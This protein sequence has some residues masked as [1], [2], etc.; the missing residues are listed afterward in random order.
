MSE[1]TTEAGEFDALPAGVP[2]G[3]QP[4]LAYRFW[5]VDLGGTVYSFTGPTR[6]VGHEWVT[7]TC[8]WPKVPWEHAAPLEGCS[9]G[10]YALKSRELAQMFFGYLLRPQTPGPQ[11]ATRHGAFVGGVLELA[12][13]I[14][15]HDRGYRA[16]RV[17]IVEILP[18]A[19]DEGR[20]ARAAPHI[21]A[22]VAKQIG[23]RLGDPIEPIMD[24]Y[25]P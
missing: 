22:R 7:A 5:W 4:I 3:I 21:A 8:A 12:G 16:Q 11:L 14:I 2:D 20:A 19:W 15:E 9:C 17:R 13:K 1:S 10:I 6:W 24:A 18:A 23:V 25:E